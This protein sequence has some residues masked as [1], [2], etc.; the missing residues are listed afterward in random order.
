MFTG[1]MTPA[2]SCP[3]LV[4][5]KTKKEREKQNKI[6]TKQRFSHLLL[7]LLGIF[8][9]Y[10]VES[11]CMWGYILRQLVNPKLHIVRI[12]LENPLNLP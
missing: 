10:T 12:A 5:S 3:A 7:S 2:L 9:W 4:T 6:H 11:H 8:L 1:G